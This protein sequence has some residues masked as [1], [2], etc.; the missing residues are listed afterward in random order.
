MWGFP[1]WKGDK[2]YKPSH[3]SSSEDKYHHAHDEVWMRLFC[4]TGI[5]VF[6]HSVFVDCK[7]GKSFCKTAAAGSSWNHPLGWY[8]PKGNGM[9]SQKAWE[10]HL[11]GQTIQFSSFCATCLQVTG[12]CLLDAITRPWLAM[13][14]PVATK[15]RG[16][17]QKKAVASKGLTSSKMGISFSPKRKEH[18]CVN[19]PWISSRLNSI[20]HIHPDMNYKKTQASPFNPY[21]L[22]EDWIFP[23]MA[24]NNP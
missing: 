17:S 14:E 4:K 13:L 10:Y 3:K 20:H 5:Y 2:C 24:R 9:S 6:G 12:K 19:A 22:T 23:T 16:S 1:C 18:I 21:V 8:S 7:T 11:V 15:C